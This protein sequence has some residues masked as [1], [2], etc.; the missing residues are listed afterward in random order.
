MRSLIIG[1]CVGALA[2]ILD[3][4]PMLLKRLAPRSIASAFVQWLVLGLVIA[5]VQSPLPRWASGLAVGLLCS[6]P[7][8]ILVSESEPAS[9]PVVLLTSSV[10]GALCGLAVGALG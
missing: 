9:V 10:L 6:I 7:I 3:I 5:H 8:A 4:A 1:L 2:G